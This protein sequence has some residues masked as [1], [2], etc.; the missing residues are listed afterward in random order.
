M[1]DDAVR[2]ILRERLQAGLPTDP[3]TIRGLGV[4]YGSD[5]LCRLGL[6]VEHE[7]ARRVTGSDADHREDAYASEMAPWTSRNAA[8]GVLSATSGYQSPAAATTGA[9]MA[10]A[11]SAADITARASQRLTLL[12]RLRELVG[13]PHLATGALVLATITRLY[14]RLR[15]AMGRTR[16]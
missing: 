10:L 13:G 5:R 8:V 3:T 16:T 9:P 4:A 1:R 12:P 2:A 15:R 11:V 7:L 6:Q 14:A